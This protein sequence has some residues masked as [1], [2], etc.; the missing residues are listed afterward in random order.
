VTFLLDTNVVSEWAK[1]QLDPGVVAWL[2]TTDENSLFISV[3]TI[4]ELRLGIE[5][6]PQGARRN[7]L[8]AWLT[9]ELAPRFDTRIFAVGPSTAGIWGRITARRQ[10]AGRPISV[11]DA[12]LAATAEE[13]DLTVVTRNVSDFAATGIRLINPWTGA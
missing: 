11:T 10:A 2:D 13:H 8:D 7:R 5:S 1:P 4:G 12:Y 3:I 9:Q 6:L